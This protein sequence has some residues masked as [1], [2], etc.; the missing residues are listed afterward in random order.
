MAHNPIF[1]SDPVKPVSSTAEG[2]A[3]NDAAG[4][5]A[6]VGE[7]DLADLAAQ[8]AAH[9]GGR[10]SPELSADLA[11]EIL[12]NEIV[13]EARVATGASGAAI[14]LERGG[15]WVCRATAGSN[16]PHLGVRLDTASALR[17][18]ANR[19]ARRHRG[20][21]DSRSAL[22]NCSAAVAER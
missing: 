20:M 8:L 6:R 18:C 1:G 11:L 14:V 2:M 7:S 9:G 17:R 10:V 16:A 4:R 3:E 15:E 19:P 22:G 12:L 13:E 21:P 5:A